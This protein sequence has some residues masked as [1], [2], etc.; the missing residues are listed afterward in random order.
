MAGD[1]FAKSSKKAKPTAEGN[2]FKRGA[3]EVGELA[4]SIPHI[5][6]GLATEAGDI[7]ATYLGTGSAKRKRQAEERIVGLGGTKSGKPGKDFGESARNVAALPGFRLLPGAHTLA[8]LTT[9]QGREE[10]GA[11]PLGTFLDILPYGSAATKTLTAGTK[12]A[13]EAENTARLAGKIKRADQIAEKGLNLKQA[14]GAGVRAA[15]EAAIQRYPTLASKVPTRLP[16]RLGFGQPTRTASRI[17]NAGDAAYAAGVDDII[18][19]ADAAAKGLDTQKLARVAT[20]G[21]ADEMAAL[22][23]AERSYLQQ[24]ADIHAPEAA[25]QIEQGKLVQHGDEIYTN[26]RGTV[27]GKQT[28]LRKA[29]KYRDAVEAKALRATDETE[30]N[31]L[32]ELHAKLGED[33]DR[34][35]AKHP[36]VRFMPLITEAATEDV[37]KALPGLDEVQQTLVRSGH[38]EDVPGALKEWRKALKSRVA[39]W[40]ELKQTHDPMFLHQVTKD[41]SKALMNPK[42]SGP[43]LKAESISKRR[44]WRPTDIIEDTR[45]S[46]SHAKA[47]RLRTELT[48]KTITDLTD[49]GVFRPLEAAKPELNKVALAYAKS[50]GLSF[51][52]AFSDVKRAT[53]DEVTVAGTRGRFG[54]PNTYLVPKGMGRAFEMMA[55]PKLSPLM[56][57]FAKANK[58]LSFAVLEANPM[59]LPGQAI[60]NSYLLL[61]EMGPK[62]FSQ[63]RRT[64]KALKEGTLPPEIVR[65]PVFSTE[66]GLSD[67][68]HQASAGQTIR[69][70]LGEGPGTALEKA[71]RADQRVKRFMSLAD[72]M[73]QGMAYYQGLEDAARQGLKGAEKQASAMDAVMRTLGVMEELTPI[74]RTTMKVVGP[75][76]SWSRFIVTKALNLPFD[77]PWRVAVLSSLAR[78]EMADW[79]SDLPTKFRGSLFL[80]KPKPDGTVKALSMGQ[81]NPYASVGSYF[82][83]AGLLGRTNPA[84][85]ALLSQTGWGANSPGLDL[86]PNLR[87][88]AETGREEYAPP[89]LVHELIANYVPQAG[90]AIDLYAPNAD[91]QAL[92]ASNPE[93]YARR[94]RG[95]LGPALGTLP[96]GGKWDPSLGLVKDYNLQEEQTKAAK[97]QGRVERS[98]A[99]AAK[100]SGGDLFAK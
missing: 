62:A 76:Y 8:G 87:M 83:L 45:L 94:I 60:S 85:Q 3:R 51:E 84:V 23:D 74:E 65:G 40:Q 14:A 91:L 13:S 70:W 86:Y 20:K 99:K 69:R 80:G 77:H 7:G 12:L 48:Q 63:F 42:L 55:N 17:V 97:A 50:H 34:M 100:K 52:Q 9:K 29:V 30:L 66:A 28:T 31:Q 22:S 10:L 67:A 2:V 68:I 19:D 26:A 33:I 96:V 41:Q 78:I 4:K 49:A 38:F 24:V 98:R 90:A 59:Y 53:Y 11:H 21:T 61:E 25:R 6:G 88:N 75:Y 16:T 36:P 43:F 15:E 79:P 39:N 72:D 5:P 1:L 82:T 89:S 18:K 56:K 93:A 95:E 58:V 44:S 47:E 32:A 37:V 27:L 35:V 64:W 73:T 92:K 71:K 54:G 46:V 81:F 57:P